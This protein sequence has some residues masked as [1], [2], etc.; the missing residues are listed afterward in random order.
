[1]SLCLILLA[2]GDSK[3]LKSNLPKPFILVNNKTIIEHSLRILKLN[4]KIRKIILVFNKKH[5]KK[6]DQIKNNDLIKI[7]GGKTRKVST[8]KGL[9]V[10]KKLKFS[11]VLIHDAA[12][13]NLSDKL[14]KNIINK[15][16]SNKAVVPYI[17]VKDTIKYKRNIVQNKKRENYMLTQTPQGFD[18]KDILNLHKKYK[19][20][21]FTDDASLFVREK[22]KIKFIN[23]E[24]ENF[25]ITNN[26]DL[27]LFK[28]IK[29]G[30]T[31][32]GI[33]FDIHKLERGRKLYL[34]GIKIPYHSGLKGH[35][36]GDVIIHAL[37]D[38]L[39]GACKSKDIGT[40]FSNKSSKFKNIRSIKLLK[41]VLDLIGVKGYEINNIDIN[42]IAERPKINKHRN[43]IIN[44]I[45]KLCNIS[46][47]QINIKGKTAEKLG[48]IGK[49]KAIASEVITSVIK[50]D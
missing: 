10:A 30:I 7:T 9:L 22:R 46:E 41:K 44:S 19:N 18:L 14:L 17:K 21:D 4:K 13:A 1:M 31:S 45:S 16:S 25:K 11:K 8:L 40:L 37:I 26:K 36:D 35:S 33:G 48:L 12:R 5:K 24:E 28:K 47:K 2:A 20:T 15:L 3:R 27:K 34:G 42:V 39:L 50:Y 23:G 29:S 43:K 49:E 38:G 6:I 32:Y